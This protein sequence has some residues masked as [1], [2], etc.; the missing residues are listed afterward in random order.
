MIAE[1]SLRKEL[2]KASYKTKELEDVIS[3]MKSK[4]CSDALTIRHGMGENENLIRE[5]E[6]LKENIDHM[7]IENQDMKKENELLKEKAFSLE[8]QNIYLRNGVDNTQEKLDSVNRELERTKNLLNTQKQIS[9]GSSKQREPIEE[10][11]ESKYL[12]EYVELTSYFHSFPNRDMDVI[13]I[14]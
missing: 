1:D 9:R 11:K 4:I 14:A 12:Q 7:N 6:N 8:K 5:I 10:L 2:E 3:K 13:L